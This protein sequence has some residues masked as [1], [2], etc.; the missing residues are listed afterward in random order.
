MVNGRE[1]AWR[2]R[3]QG[4]ECQNI[5]LSGVS[6]VRLVDRRPTYSDE[7]KFGLS[8]ARSKTRISVSRSR[9][10]TPPQAPVGERQ[11]MVQLSRPNV[12]K[13]SMRQST[14][15][16]RQRARALTALSV[17]LDPDPALFGNSGSAR[18][19]KVLYRCRMGRFVSSGRSPQTGDRAL[20]DRGGA[21][22]V[23]PLARK[24]FGTD[25]IAGMIRATWAGAPL[26]ARR[27]P[28]GR[29]HPPM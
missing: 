17:M 5:P 29:N 25:A 28:R 12:P 7:T 1:N 18:V 26:L 21:P 2:G 9:G 6:P 3:R 23:H 20:L 22:P 11:G 16:S 10:R 19:G 15:A 8:G 13:V 4:R 14:H 24:R 27:K